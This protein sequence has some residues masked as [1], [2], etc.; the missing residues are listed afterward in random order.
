MTAGANAIR[1]ARRLHTLDGQGAAWADALVGMVTG[2]ELHA[3]ERSFKMSAGQLLCERFLVGLRP[4]AWPKLRLDH[5]CSHLAMPERSFA[6]LAAD[7]ERANLLG[8]AFEESRGRRRFKAYAEFP[9]PARRQ[10]GPVPGTAAAHLICH[11]YKWD[12]DRGVD[13]ALTRYWYAPGLSFE[14]IST[15]LAQHEQARAPAAIRTA[16]QALLARCR[17]RATAADLMYV[18]A[19]ED[20][21][22]RV[23]FDLNFYAATLRMEDVADIVRPT[24][25]AFAIEAGLLDRFLGSIS[26]RVVGHISAG[27]DRDGSDFLTLYYQH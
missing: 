22:S 13:A 4:P 2:I 9:V 10:P 23:S 24:G 15:C 6:L 12:P 11:G 7:L 21:G 3:I 27:I 17:G 19:R 20:G 25:Q 5:L 16:P 18:E 26:D 14:E 1:E 8:L